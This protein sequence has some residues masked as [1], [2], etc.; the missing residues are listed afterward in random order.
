[1]S[2]AAASQAKLVEDIKSV[3]ADAEDVLHATADQAGEKVSQLR[4]RIQKRLEGARSRLSEAEAA[5]MAK[6]RAAARATDAYVHESPWSSVGIAA[7]VGVL[8]GLILGRR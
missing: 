5:L 1:M 4:T 3:I 7:G 6:T 8:V 2:N